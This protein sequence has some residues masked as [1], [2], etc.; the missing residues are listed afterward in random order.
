[1][2]ALLHRVS[3]NGAFLVRLRAAADK[4]AFPYVLVVWAD[5]AVHNLPIAV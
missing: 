1:M 2:P 5:S 4:H 3:L